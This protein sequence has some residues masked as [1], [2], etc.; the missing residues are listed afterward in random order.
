MGNKSTFLFILFSTV[1]F[2]QTNINSNL[3][4]IDFS[5]Y[6][7]GFYAYDFNNPNELKKQDFFYNHNRHNEFNINLALV[8]AFVSYENLYAKLS[9]H[10]GTYV[11]D[12]YSNESI[13]NINEAFLGVYLDAAKKNNIEFGIFSSYIGF[14][15]A[16]TGS[17]L[18]LTRSILA[19][20]SPYFMTGVK[21]NYKPSA[22]WVFSGMLSNGWQRI[23]K[24]D[25]RV[26]PAVGTQI[27]F[28]PVD[29]STFNW[30]T[31]FGKEYY[32]TKLGVRY[33]SNLYW[34]KMWNSKWRTI[35]GYDFGIQET[36]SNL[37]LT[38][39][40]LAENSPYFMTGVRYNYKP[41]AKWMFSG[42]LSN[43]WQ[44][45]SKQDKRVAPAI[46]T[47]IIF[48]PADNSTFNW[49]T[50][51][52]K[53]YYGTHLG[54]R[55]FSNLYW[56]KSWNSKWRTILG[57]DFGIQETRFKDNK[58]N[59]WMSPVLIAQYTINDKWQSAVRFEYYQDKENIIITT[60]SPFDTKGYSLNFDYIINSKAKFR[61]EA[62]YLDSQ[63][64]I[65]YDNNSNN[66]S[67]TTSLSYEFN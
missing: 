58:F 47:Q 60:S 21:Y 33:F 48:K 36:S 44:R 6:I 15:S 32:G 40:M 49:S 67:L 61:M 22:K 54:M 51:F 24:Q 55:Y 3:V 41:S 16:I 35:L 46:G 31:F 34:D 53:E 19:E 59:H 9:F 62:R 13:K 30:S 12:N 17:N 1:C 5:G 4:K 25:K 45:I 29:N 50:F 66:F 23:S 10:G 65:F 63:E 2:A 64:A 8:S 37:T 38:R 57:Y 56:D 27:I 7:D 52:G 14:E 18:T 42:M 39:S 11:D 20:N 28:K 43:G 26:A